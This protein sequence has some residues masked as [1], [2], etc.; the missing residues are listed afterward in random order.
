MALRHGGTI[1]QQFLK[2]ALPQSREPVAGKRKICETYRA[3]F[4]PPEAAPANPLRT[5]SGTGDI[6]TVVEA[7]GF[8]SHLWWVGIRVHNCC[9]QIGAR[10]SSRGAAQRTNGVPIMY[11]G[12]CEAGAGIST[13]AMSEYSNPEPR[14]GTDRI[15]DQECSD[16][17]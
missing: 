5:N 16:P 12:L 11:I 10:W 14:T 2:I 9:H 3:S 7:L 13:F 4:A 17:E 8:P 6:S 15:R 1:Q